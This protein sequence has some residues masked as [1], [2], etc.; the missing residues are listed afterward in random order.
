MKGETVL[1][2]GCVGAIG[3]ALVAALGCSPHADREAL[4]RQKPDAASHAV[5]SQ[6]LRKIMADLDD[7]RSKRLPQEMDARSGLAAHVDD[8][9]STAQ[10]L[11]LAAE[12]IPSVLTEVHL[13]PSEEALFH[14]LAERLRVAALQLRDQ[15]STADPAAI[16][17]AFED[18][19]SA[20]NACHSRFRVMPAAGA[21]PRNDGERR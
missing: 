3:L 10:S 19:V 9:R 7:I 6:A 18:V 15:A 13:S 11:A 1:S 14:Q 2:R 4:E 5:R 8:I 20:C 17:R 12:S 16:A 21:M